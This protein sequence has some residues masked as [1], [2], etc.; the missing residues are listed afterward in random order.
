MLEKEVHV[1]N[2]R[3]RTELIQKPAKVL[4]VYE[5]QLLHFVNMNG[6]HNGDKNGIISRH[7]LYKG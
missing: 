3:T 5:S 4:S 2:T 7:K 1:T 6:S